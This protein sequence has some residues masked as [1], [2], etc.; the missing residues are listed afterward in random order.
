MLTTAPFALPTIPAAAHSATVLGTS[1][2]P[3]GVVFGIGAGMSGTDSWSKQDRR[4]L[5]GAG[6]LARW[7]R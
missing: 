4:N 5:S 3:G 6:D 1:C 7:A 2:A